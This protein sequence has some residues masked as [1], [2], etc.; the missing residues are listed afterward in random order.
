[1][2]RIIIDVEDGAFDHLEELILKSFVPSLQV[3]GLKPLRAA[4]TS[5]MSEIHVPKIIRLG[6]SVQEA[7]VALPEPSS[8]PPEF[9][10]GQRVVLYD[11]EGG[12][13]G[14]GEITAES[15]LGGLYNVFTDTEETF[16]DVVAAR[17]APL[18]EDD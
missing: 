1:M 18:G 10:V 2:S 9:E 4:I 15:K 7:T 17:I 12:Y 11:E 14:E 3:N 8:D 6:E 16:E 5:D 13:I